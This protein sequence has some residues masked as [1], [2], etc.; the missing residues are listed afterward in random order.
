M[1]EQTE[2]MLQ[3]ISDYKKMDSSDSTIIDRQN[4][5]F[6]DQIDGVIRPPQL[7]EVIYPSLPPG[8]SFEAFLE[9]IGSEK[10]NK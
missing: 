1:N 10:K 4:K 7:A 6:R 8:N 3:L 5:Y 9:K 2:L